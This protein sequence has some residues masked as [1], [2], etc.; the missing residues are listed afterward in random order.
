MGREVLGLS[1]GSPVYVFLV[2]LVYSEK[3]KKISYFLTLLGKLFQIQF[4]F[5]F[6]VL[7]YSQNI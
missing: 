6:Q 2:K 7:L 3:A 4:G 5:F 1:W